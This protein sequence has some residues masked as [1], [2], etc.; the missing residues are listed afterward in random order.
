MKVKK[1]IGFDSTEDHRT[2]AT[3]GAGKVCPDP[4]LPDYGDRYEMVYPL[5]IWGYDRVACG[6]IIA[7]AGLPVPPKSACFFCPSMKEAEIMELQATEPELYALALEME[8]LYREGKHFRG[9]DAYTIKAVRKDTDEKVELELFGPD[10]A[11]VTAEFRR[12]YDDTTKPYR[13]KVRAYLAV[14]GL[15]RS[16]AWARMP[17]PM[18]GGSTVWG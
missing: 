8:R 4:D 6:K 12:R 5:R 9:D 3:G 10:A 18:V 13:Y 1:L 14:P 17:L 2:Y 7:K 15:G 11:S 16:F